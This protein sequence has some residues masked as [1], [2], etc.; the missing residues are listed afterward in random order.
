MRKICLL[1]YGDNEEWIKGRAK[2]SAKR[3]SKEIARAGALPIVLCGVVVGH[4]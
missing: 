1:E 4:V 3:N 2:M